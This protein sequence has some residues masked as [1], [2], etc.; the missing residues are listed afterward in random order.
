MAYQPKSYRKF[1]AGSVTAALVATAVAPVAAAD[2]N[3]T[4]V[5]GVDA[6]LLA[7][8][9]ALVD[10]GAINNADKFNPWDAAKRGQFAKMLAASLGLSPIESET[11]FTDVASFEDAG[12]LFAL[13]AAGVEISGYENGTL[14]KPFNELSRAAAAKLI[15]QAL[16]LENTGDEVSFT[17]L[18]AV[19]AEDREYIQIAAQHGIFNDA[20]KFNPYQPL[21]RA[22]LALVLYRA[23]QNGLIGL[24]VSE[25]V[26]VDADTLSVTMSN[27]EVYDVELAEAL[28][29]NVETEVTFEIEGTE[30]TAV[31]TYVV[32]EATVTG[33]EALNLIQLNVELSTVAGLDEDTLTDEAKYDLS[34]SDGTDIEV[35]SVELNG[36]TLTLT[37]V[38]NVD[39]QDTATLTINKDVLG[40]DE[41]LEIEDI[42]FFDAVVPVAES[43]EL[44]GPNKFKVYFSEPVQD[45]NTNTVEVENGIYGVSSITVDGNVATVELSADSLKEGEYEIKVSDFKDYAEFKALTKTFTLDYVK[46]T[47]APVA[48]ITK[49]T[50]TEV[51]IKFNKPVVLDEE[52]LEDYFYHTYSAYTPDSVETDDNQEFTL[53]FDTNPLGEG[54]V[55]VV[56][57]YNANDVEIEDE[58]GNEMAGN[59]EFFVDITADKTAP[60]VS[61][62]TVEDEKEI[63]VYFSEE[64]VD[65]D[66]DNFKFFDADGEELDQSFTVSDVDQDDDDQYFVTI[67]FSGDDLNGDYTVE[68][69]D[70]EDAALEPNEMKT[71]T[72]SFSVEDSTGIDLTEVEAVGV[73]GDSADYIYV[74]FPE[75]MATDGQ[76]SVLE[77]SNYL[78]NGETLGDS[79][80]IEVFKESNK[81]KITLADEDDFD[82]SEEKSEFLSIARVADLAG[83]KS[84]MLSTKVDVTPDVSPAITA[85]EQVDYKTIKITLDKP[86]KTVVASGFEVTNGEATATLA[87]VSWEINDDNE[88][89]VTGTLKSTTQVS[90][91]NTADLIDSVRIVADK[92]ESETGRTVETGTFSDI[93]DAYA[94]EFSEATRTE[95]GNVSEIELTFT[96]VVTAGGPASTALA[97]SYFTVVDESGDELTLVLSM[98]DLDEED[99]F[100]VQFN[101]DET[102]TVYVYGKGEEDLDIEL[103]EN[104]YFKDAAGNKVAKFEET[105]DVVDAD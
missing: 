26:V 31:V 102:V 17:D 55:K 28:E 53:T 15:V 90:E 19:D 47:A 38:D 27:G 81:V 24:T 75:K 37:L 29:A 16:G 48:E 82:F 88:T 2:L 43:I 65:V 70:I 4:D 97:S 52:N 42:E 84:T 50:Q 44:V 22:Q 46:D 23:Q 32:T 89:V 57:D 18:G 25:T 93:D 67:N 56:V 104:K 72:M 39:N 13:Q 1:L 78:V 33:V 74:T 85:V 69:K 101:G 80:K 10:Q 77:K 66:E 79:D 98:D 95:D 86:L 49:A 94:P 3:F 73:D 14:F 92:L 105:V 51:K 58:W 100:F 76:Y 96:E 9:N 54:T 41:D 60:E 91:D 8:L 20:D 61:K 35:D 7:A 103:V 6:E 21:K 63:K 40:T 68:V 99:E 11:T 12:Y 62:I 45:L 30:Y 59:A 83:N 5:E 71:V 36:T 87:A 64:V 34:T